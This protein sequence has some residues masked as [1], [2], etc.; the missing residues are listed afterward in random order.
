MI[1][2]QF[3]WMNCETRWTEGAFAQALSRLPNRP[4]LVVL[5]GVNA[6]ASQHDTEVMH[7]KSVAV[8]R[9]LF[10]KP[11]TAL[12]AT[13]LS[14][15][16]PVKDRARQGER[17]SFGS[18]AWLDEVDGV[19][20]RLE[21][22]PK[23]IAKG[24]EGASRL[25]VVKDRYGSVKRHGQPNANKEAG[26]FYL[27]SFVVD[28]SMPDVNLGTAAFVAAPKPQTQGPQGFQLG[29]VGEGA[30]DAPRS[31]GQ[32]EDDAA[33][34]A[35]VTEIV[36]KG[37]TATGNAVEA[38]VKGISNERTR[39]ALER[40]VING[41]L[42]EGRGARNARIFHLS[43]PL[44]A[45]QWHAAFGSTTSPHDHRE[46]IFTTSQFTSPTDLAPIGPGEVRRGDY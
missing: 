39:R 24:R 7:P 38:C 29:E 43:N 16:H 1:L 41:K 26:W 11:A 27:G 46:K 37:K 34:L 35:Q 45:D 18:T 9:T 17:H 30:E 36:M 20:F 15:G 12:G 32:A 14:L 33:V 6:A 19:A 23:L 21:A 5:D 13:V 28:D 4:T 2:K 10:V 40:L 25:S 22:S 44:G 3:R 42:T 31:D 8:Y